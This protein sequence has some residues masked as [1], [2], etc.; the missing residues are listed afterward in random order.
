MDLWAN[1]FTF[2][3]ARPSCSKFKGTL[4][5][6]CGADLSYVRLTQH[7]TL[8]T[9]LARFQLMIAFVF[10]RKECAL[11]KSCNKRNKYWNILAHLVLN[12]TN[13]PIYFVTQYET[14]IYIESLF[15]LFVLNSTIAKVRLSIF[16]LPVYVEIEYQL[17]ANLWHAW[18]EFQ[19]R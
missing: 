10:H 3:S 7:R 13:I 6:A 17:F 4:F 5:I 1:V 14:L 11:L 15:D 8:C 19:H 18:C 12:I 9:I 2:L 16:V